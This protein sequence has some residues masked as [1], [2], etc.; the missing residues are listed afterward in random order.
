M[1]FG[2]LIFGINWLIYNLFTL[3]F[4]RVSALDLLY[5]CIFDALAIS[6]GVSISI[7]VSR[8]RETL[9]KAE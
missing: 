2:G 5:R 4:I 6:I 1:I 9:Q 3:L 7:F 8:K